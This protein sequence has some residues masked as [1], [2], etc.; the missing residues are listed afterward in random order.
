[1]KPQNLAA[2]RL[3]FR[4]ILLHCNCVGQVLSRLLH[5]AIES[6]NKSL[7]GSVPSSA[8]RRHV[9]PVLKLKE[10]PTGRKK[11]ESGIVHFLSIFNPWRG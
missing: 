9:H 11:K 10:I 6:I 2:I 8:S 7:S 1:M 4:L 5:L 3:P